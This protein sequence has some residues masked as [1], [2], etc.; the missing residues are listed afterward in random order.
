MLASQPKLHFSLPLQHA[1][2]GVG[3]VQSQVI[4]TGSILADIALFW[5]LSTVTFSVDILVVFCQLAK[6]W[7]STA[8]NSHIVF[9][10]ISS[11]CS[12]SKLA[13]LT[14]FKHCERKDC[15]PL[16]TA[17]ADQFT[18]LIKSTR[19]FVFSKQF[20]ILQRNHK[21]SSLQA[22][23]AKLFHNLF[24]FLGLA[25]WHLSYL[26][27]QLI[28]VLNSGTLFTNCAIRF[29]NFKFGHTE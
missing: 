6:S 26:F 21:K 19:N 17:A 4:W 14:C 27:V 2:S 5:V 11:A 24:A 3:I 28:V 1:G 13:A 18:I 16:S 7:A 15:W 23:H 20:P 10:C 9:T 12:H 22:R 29:Y 8:L 25:G